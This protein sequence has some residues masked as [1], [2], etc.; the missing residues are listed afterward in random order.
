[1]KGQRDDIAPLISREKFISRSIISASFSLVEAFLSGLFFTALHTNT[2]GSL[3]CDEEFL[4]YA[5]KKESEALN[6]RVD[7]IVKFASLGKTDG[8]S[9]PFK[10]F[11][12]VGKRYRDAIH[13]TTPFGRNDLEAGQRLISL[14]EINPN[15]AAICSLLSLNCVL[16]ISNWIYGDGAGSAITDS[17]KELRE[18]VVLW[19]LRQGQATII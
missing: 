7:R 19:S 10:S 2:L 9:D 15:V 1:M 5:E 6:R 12:E 17:C 8:A 16:T 11:I 18:R 14:Y 13:H 3:H 4:R